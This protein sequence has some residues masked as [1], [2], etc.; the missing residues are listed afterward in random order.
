MCSLERVYGE[1]LLLKLQEEEK[2]AAS[3]AG[4]DSVPDRTEP[5]LVPARADRRRV[6]ALARWVSTVLRPSKLGLPA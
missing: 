5:L 6:F 2:N 1:L 3:Q 4:I